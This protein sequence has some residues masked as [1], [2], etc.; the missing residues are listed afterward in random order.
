MQ[1]IH[2]NNIKRAL[3]EVDITRIYDFVK[4][5]DLRRGLVIFVGIQ[6]GTRPACRRQG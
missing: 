1:I 5:M 4:L 3:N 6:S 2:E